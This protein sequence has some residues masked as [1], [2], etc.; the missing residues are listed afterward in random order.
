VSA[1]VGQTRNNESW[2]VEAFA[3]RDAMGNED[4]G[5]RAIYRLRF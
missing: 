5:V 4:R 3:G 1:G 2:S